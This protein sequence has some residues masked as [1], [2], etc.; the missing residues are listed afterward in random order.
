M[1]QD[2]QE[3]QPRNQFHEQLLEQVEGPA[4]ETHFEIKPDAP[5]LEIDGAGRIEWWG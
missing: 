3:Q 4:V 1:S 2:N 5:A